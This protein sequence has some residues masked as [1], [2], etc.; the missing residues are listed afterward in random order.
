VS[1]VRY[2]DRALLEAALSGARSSPRLRKN[3]NF[4]ESALHPCQRLI[5]AVLPDAYVRPHRHLDPAK[6]ETLVILSGRLGLVLFDAVGNVIERALLEAGGPKLAATIP[7]ATFHTAVAFDGGAV[8]FEAKAG[9]Y[10]PHG[11]GETAEFAPPEGT[12]EGQ[13]YLARLKDLF[14]DA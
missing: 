1:P 5:N 8:V 9:P 3:V 12:P 6:E 4:H 7:P 2:I 11:P 14:A 10:L 13:A